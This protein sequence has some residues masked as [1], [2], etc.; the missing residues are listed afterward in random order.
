LIER[1]HVIAVVDDDQRILESLQ[2]LLESV[3]YAVLTFTEATGLLAHEHMP[4]DCLITDIGMP[5]M[6]GF[7]LLEAVK[8]SN[9]SLPVFLITGRHE[10][11]DQQRA[12]ARNISGIFRKPFDTRRL[13]SEVSKAL[14]QFDGG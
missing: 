6:D 2:D 12:A 14:H 5:G 1:Q 10:I 7:D 4:V 13:L 9:P 11:A 3:G 8:Q